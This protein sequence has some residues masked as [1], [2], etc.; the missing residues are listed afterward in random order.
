[1]PLDHGLMRR[2]NGRFTFIGPMRVPT[3]L[4]TTIGNRSGQRRQI[5]LTYTREGDRLFVVASNSGGPKHPAWSLNLLANP[6]AWVTIKGVEISVTASQ[7]IGDEY[8]RLWKVFGAYS[9][10]SP[11]YQGRMDANCG[12]SP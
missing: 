8:D 10:V 2:S 9:K 6:D 11:A 12:C 7:V 1:M 4:L 3:L 5:V